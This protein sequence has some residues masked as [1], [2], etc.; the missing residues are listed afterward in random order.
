[1]IRV[2]IADDQQLVRSGLRALLERDPEMTV[3]AEAADGLEA[4]HLAEAVRP[5]V[6]LMDVRMPGVDGVEATGRVHAPVIVLTTYDGDATVFAALRAGAAGFLLKDVRPDD[7]RRAVRDVAAG[8]SIL[9]PAVTG[10]V[11]AAAARG[12]TPS[13][14]RLDG[15]TV[16]E[17]EVLAAVA[18]GH[19]NAEIADLL[20]IGEATARTHVGRLLSKLGARDRAQLVMIAYESGLVRPGD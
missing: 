10:R 8:G 19:R 7:L 6:I 4:V 1:M 16:R 2:L 14:E 5:D 3:V 9:A 18:A 17:R 11:M 12:H 13:P 20:G 15:L